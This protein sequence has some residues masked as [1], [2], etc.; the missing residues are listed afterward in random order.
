M[1]TLKNLAK[2]VMIPIVAIGLYS[3]DQDTERKLSTEEYEIKSDEIL[4]VYEDSVLPM[5]EDLG[6][7]GDSL[8][9]L[10]E[11]VKLWRDS[12]LLTYKKSDEYGKDRERFNFK[13]DSVKNIINS[14]NQRFDSAYEETHSMNKK[15]SRWVKKELDNLY[16][17]YE[18]N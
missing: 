14:M 1:K 5:V 13:K 8:T 15:C 4:R 7:K 2:L 16:K 6:L 3:C 17:K 9:V 10:Y 12:I 18:L 11:E